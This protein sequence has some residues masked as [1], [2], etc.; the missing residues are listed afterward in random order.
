MKRC[1]RRRHAQRFKGKMTVR[2]H[3]NRKDKGQK[4]DVEAVLKRP[5]E[6]TSGMM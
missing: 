2:G 6:T 1:K 4:I 5:D 3:V